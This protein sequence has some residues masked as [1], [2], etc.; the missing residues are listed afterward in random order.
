[1]NCLTDKKVALELFIGEWEKKYLDVLTKIELIDRGLIK[2]TE[3]EINEEIIKLVSFK[4]EF[5]EATVKFCNLLFNTR[6]ITATH[7][8]KDN[9]A[10]RRNYI[11][12]SI[13]IVL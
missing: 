4:R 2:P 9:V 7:C 8:F 3:E 12:N 10:D 1:M 6:G 11:R 5:K 13:K